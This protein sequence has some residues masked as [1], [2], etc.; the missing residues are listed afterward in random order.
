MQDLKVAKAQGVRV[1]VR[2]QTSV[3]TNFGKLR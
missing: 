3:R 1:H 2:V